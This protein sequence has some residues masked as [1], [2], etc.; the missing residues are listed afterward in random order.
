MNA[1]KSFVLALVA[2]AGCAQLLAPIANVNVV[3]VEQEAQISSQFVKEVESKQ[4]IVRDSEVQDYVSRLGGRLA[5]TIARPDF[6]FVFRVVDDASVNAFNVGGGHVYVHSGMLKAAETEGQLASVLAHEMGHQTHRHVA[7]MISREQLFQTL[8][9][10]AVGP[11]ASQWMQLGASLGLTTGQLYFGREAEREADREM[12]PTLARA[13]YDPREAL[14][15][16]AVLE[17][18]NQSQP[19]AVAALFSSHP[20]TQERIDNVRRE[21]EATTLPKDLASDSTAFQRIRGR[22]GGS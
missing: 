15:M 21:I 3:S 14:G 8:A 10:V 17:K 19:G 4:P 7:K 1:N 16:F 20:P 9:S 12:V 13:G 11:N 18:I 6:P 5:S 22:L 2:A